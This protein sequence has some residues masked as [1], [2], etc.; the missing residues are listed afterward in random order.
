M[1]YDWGRTGNPG[2]AAVHRFCTW[3]IT[4]AAIV[5]CPLFLFGAVAMDWTLAFP[6]F[7]IGGGAVAQR[8]AVRKIYGVRERPAVETGPVKTRAEEIAEAVEAL[9]QR[10]WD[11]IA[12]RAYLAAGGTA[13]S[14]RRTP[15]TRSQ[16]VVARPASS[17]ARKAPEGRPDSGAV[18]LDPRWE[19]HLVRGI[20]VPDR[21]VKARCRHLEVDPVKSLSGEVVAQLCLTC[22][23]QFPPPREP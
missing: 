15:A 13:D 16:Q 21:W 17:V 6:A 3:W 20:G 8:V 5:A 23:T 2:T 9:R 4:I 10:Q 19:W 7:L 22:D 14:K 1:R 18:E 12:D 11:A